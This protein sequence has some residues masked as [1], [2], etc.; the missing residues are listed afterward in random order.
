MNVIVRLE[1]ELAYYDSAV[2]RFTTIPQSNALHH[3][4]THRFKNCT[5]QSTRTPPHNWKS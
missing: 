5:K 3:E 1:Y 4:D 2:Q